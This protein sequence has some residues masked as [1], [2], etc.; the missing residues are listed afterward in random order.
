MYF[1]IILGVLTITTEEIESIIILNQ[2]AAYELVNTEDG[3]IASFS[4]KGN[5]E[6]LV[7]HCK[8]NKAW[9][10]V[11]DWFKNYQKEIIE[12]MTEEHKK[13]SKK[14]RF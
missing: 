10:N 1:S 14:A 12:G 3:G 6:E 13:E 5:H 7:Y 9:G 2:I 11:L 4:L 8:G